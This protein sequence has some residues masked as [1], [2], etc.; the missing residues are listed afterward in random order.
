MTVTTRQVPFQT[1]K[2]ARNAS[3]MVTS[4]K[5]QSETVIHRRLSK[6]VSGAF[7]TLLARTVISVYRA[8]GAMLSRQKNVTHV[9]AFS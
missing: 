3:V 4:T 8:T 6:F 2:R 5:M 9:S 7:T 1:S